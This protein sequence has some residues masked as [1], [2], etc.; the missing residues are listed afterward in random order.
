MKRE[1]LFFYSVRLLLTVGIG[2]VLLMLYWSN[3]L[4]EQ[5]LFDI[6]EQ[7]EN[8]EIPACPAPTTPV[9]A[10]AA[11]ARPHLDDTYPNLLEE[12]PFYQT[13]LPQELLPQDFTPQGTLFSATYGVPSDLHPFSNWSQVSAFNSLCQVSLAKN[14]F[15]IFETYSPDMAIKIE[16]RPRKGGGDEFWIH[17]RQGVYWRPLQSGWFSEKLAPWFLK[18][19]PVTAED[20]KFAFDA[21]VNPHVQLAGAV[22]ARTQYSEI[23]E[24]EVIDPLTFI[25]RWKRHEVDG[26]MK[27][28]F[29]ATQRTGSLTPL[30]GFIYKYFPDGTKIIEEDNYST[31]SV[32]AQNFAEHW[33]RHIIASCGAWSFDGM[34]EKKIQFVR[35]PDHYFP[36]DAL[37]LEQQVYFKNSADGIWQDFKAGRLSTYVLQ[38]DQLLEWEDFQNSEIYQKQTEKIKRLDY[39]ARSYFYIGW[40]MANDL[41]ASSKVRLAMT[42]AIDRQRIIRQNLGGLGVEITGPFYLTSPSYNKE[43]TPWPFDPTRA[44]L[45]LAEE[46]WE[47]TDGDGV[48]D[49]EIGGKRVPFRFTLTYFVK[50]QTTRAIVQ[51]IATALNQIGVDC[52]PKGVDMTDLSAAFDGKDFDA[53]TLGWGLG[54]PPEDPKQLW[55]SKGAKE[56]GSSNAVGFVNE[57]ADTII[58]KLQFEEDTDKRLALYHRFHEIIHEQQPYTFL[59]TPKTVL[60][61]RESIQNVFLPIKRQDLIPGANIA[62]PSSAIFWIKN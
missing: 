19:H 53:L 36:L 23:E 54:A 28:V 60:L 51:Y 12:D 50:N 41:F 46:G 2:V 11:V 18:P 38:P 59:Y 9:T 31:N 52:E 45:I 40:N 49:K 58:N 14:K 20:Y 44:R 35:N 5:Q 27:S 48:L 17:L 33:A 42:L 61:Y 24:I 37:T 15:G 3:L 16:K 56:R 34:S 21:I 8:I 4:V 7:L 43:I 39:M 57:E 30:A 62:E 1:P 32:W 6:K 29:T 47:D 13:I 25:V 55:E 10:S 26:K 22:A